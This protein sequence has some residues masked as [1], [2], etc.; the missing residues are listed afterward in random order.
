MKIISAALG[1]CSVVFMSGCSEW[2]TMKCGDAE[3]LSVANQIIDKKI[4][5]PLITGITFNVDGIRT[6]S[7]DQKTG[8]I[9]CSAELKINLPDG[10]TI[11]LPITYTAER[12]DDGKQVFVTMYGLN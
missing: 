1:F 3:V 7:T 10:R 2:K 5:N 4:R 11:P 12:T 6:T 8:T 9:Q